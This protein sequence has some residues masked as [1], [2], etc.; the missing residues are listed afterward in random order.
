MDLQKYVN[1]AK[2]SKSPNGN[3]IAQTERNALKKVVV[4]DLAEQLQKVYPD[5]QVFK[6]EEG[7]AIAFYN[8]HL[9]QDITVI[10]SATMKDFS[11][12]AGEEA[13]AFKSLA[14]DKAKEKELKAKLKATTKKG[15]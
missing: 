2:F 5:A 4:S 7:V 14:D 10:V 3:G 9:D 13:E 8:E 11:Y 1:E 12:N 15:K 6:V